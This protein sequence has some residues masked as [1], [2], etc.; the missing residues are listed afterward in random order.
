MDINGTVM[1]AK[2]NSIKTFCKNN[3]SLSVYFKILEGH[4]LQ[5]E[6]RSVERKKISAE[7]A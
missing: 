3:F 1:S 4:L 6:G 5:V 7:K 2:C